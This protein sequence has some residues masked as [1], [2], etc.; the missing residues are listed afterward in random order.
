MATFITCV[1]I[2]A[3]CTCVSAQLLPYE[4]NPENFEWQRAS[5]LTGT[6][7]RLYAKIRSRLLNEIPLCFAMLRVLQNNANA[8]SYV[9]THLARGGLG[10]L[11]R[12]ATRLVTSRTPYHPHKNAVA[13]HLTSV[14]PRMTRFKVVYSDP[15]SNCIILIKAPPSRHRGSAAPHLVNALPPGCA[16]R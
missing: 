3:L 9:V 14:S 11:N 12:Y 4:D 15:G 8:F 10:G 2:L 7:E 13:F 16:H 5:D 6:G 1:S